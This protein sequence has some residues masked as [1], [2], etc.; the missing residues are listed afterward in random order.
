M[1]DSVRAVADAVLYEGYVLW[2][3]RRSAMKNQ[4]RWTFGGVYP[5][6]W[7]AEH[8]D[9]RREVRAEFACAGELEVRVRFLHVVRRQVEVAGEPVDEA[10][11]G[12]ERYLTWEEAVEREVGAGPIAIPAGSHRDEL[13]DGVAVVRSWQGLDGVVEVR[14]GSLVVRNETP[15]AGGTRQEALERTFC[16]LHAELHADRFDPESRSGEGL[17]PVLIDDST[18]LASPIIL[19]DRPKIAPESPGDLFD[20]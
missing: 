3:Y 12:G 15:F 2:P 7:N 17:W 4:Q 19:E 9:D 16:S 14:A 11:V 1:S 18:L 10:V 6:A 13:G 5:P 8:P 20:G